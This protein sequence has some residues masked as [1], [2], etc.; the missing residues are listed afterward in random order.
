MGLG[1][2]TQMD[3]INDLMRR[4]IYQIIEPSPSIEGKQPVIQKYDIWSLHSREQGI[5]ASG[6]FTFR[7]VEIFWERT[8]DSTSKAG[9]ISFRSDSELLAWTSVF[10]TFF[11]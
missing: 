6:G 9:R 3:N 1:A 10:K 5:N 11:N 4:N 8:P 7:S 2:H